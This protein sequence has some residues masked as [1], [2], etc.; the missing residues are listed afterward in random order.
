MTW[1]PPAGPMRTVTLAAALICAAMPSA[2][3]ACTGLLAHPVVQSKASKVLADMRGQSYLTSLSSE[4]VY[5]AFADGL[6]TEMY[7]VARKTYDKPGA[8]S[9]RTLEQFQSE[10]KTADVNTW[11]ACFPGLADLL[12]ETMQREDAAKARAA[13]AADEAKAAAVEA[14]KPVNRLLL[15]YKRYIYVK[16]CNEIRQGYAVVYVNDAELDRSRTAVKAIETAALA[17][18]DSLNTDTIWRVAARQMVG[19]GH[20]NRDQCHLEYV[21]LLDSAGGMSGPLRKDF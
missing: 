3:A 6:N 2:H 11:V 13:A 21:R 9:A 17:E 19:V 10:M 12:R 16:Y 15:A 1:K 20:A 7:E 14:K 4:G 8:F 18:D 5:R